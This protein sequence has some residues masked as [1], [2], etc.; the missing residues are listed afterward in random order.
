M[1]PS[2]L[3]AHFF[4]VAANAIP[5]ARDFPRD[6][7]FTRDQ[8]FR[9][10]AEIDDHP[11]AI[12][13]LDDAGDELAHPAFVGIDDLSAFRF[14][15]FLHDDLFGGL[16]GDATELRG[17][18]GLLD[19]VAGGDARLP[20][21]GIVQQDFALG[22]EEMRPRFFAVFVDG[23][24]FAFLRFRKQR[25]IEDHVILGNHLPAPKGLVLTAAAIDGHPNVQILAMALAGRAL[26]CG[27]DGLEDDLGGNALLVGHRLH[28][29][30]NLFAHMALEPLRIK[31][32]A[33]DQAS[34][35]SRAAPIRL[36][37]SACSAPSTSMNM[38]PL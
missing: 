38:L 27:L 4:Q 36:K 33:R 7:F 24:I 23:D 17:L 37:G 16:G 25:R 1:R 30:E 29:H 32:G 35:T 28:H 6:E 10:R 15:H 14:T 13:A 3:G 31:E 5:R 34:G 9:V 8:G 22:S 11:A 26:E 18:H 20:G 2:R 19:V 12:I 21:P